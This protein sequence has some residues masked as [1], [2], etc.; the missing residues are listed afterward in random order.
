MTD[1]LLKDCPLFYQEVRDS[2]NE[3]VGDEDNE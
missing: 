2:W 3:R 1:K